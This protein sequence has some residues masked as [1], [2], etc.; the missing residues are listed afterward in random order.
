MTHFQNKTNI[1]EKLGSKL[2]SNNVAE[3][4]KYSLIWIKNYSALG[5][6]FVYCCTPMRKS[7]IIDRDLVT[8]EFKKLKT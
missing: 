5:W 6:I 4:K 2:L 3:K 8:I 1:R 7:V